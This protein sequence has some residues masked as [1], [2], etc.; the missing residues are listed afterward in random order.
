MELGLDLGDNWLTMYNDEISHGLGTNGRG[1]DR[2]AEFQS[3]SKMCILVW[4]L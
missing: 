2:E 4:G 1:H 3:T